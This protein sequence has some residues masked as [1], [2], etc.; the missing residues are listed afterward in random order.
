MMDLTDLA[1]EPGNKQYMNQ[2]NTDKSS[3]SGQFF[4]KWKFTLWLKKKKILIYKSL[5]L[6]SAIS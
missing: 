1:T 4:G 2:K 6:T 3:P 5:L